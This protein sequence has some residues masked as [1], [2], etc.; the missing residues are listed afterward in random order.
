MQC[1]AATAA[2][3]I[4]ARYDE[5]RAAARA[6]AERHFDSDRVIGGLLADVGLS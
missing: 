6:I 2:A 4:V 3:D 1:E 5:H